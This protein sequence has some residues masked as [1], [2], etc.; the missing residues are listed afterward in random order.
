MNKYCYCWSGFETSA[1]SP[2]LLC[3]CSLAAWFPPP[4]DYAT[5]R[6]SPDG[7]PRPQNREKYISFLFK[8]S[9]LYF[10]LEAENRQD[11]F[12]NI[13]KGHYILLKFLPFHWNEILKYA[14]ERPFSPQREGSRVVSGVCFYPIVVHE[15]RWGAGG[16]SP[17]L[18]PAENTAS[19]LLNCIYRLFLL[20]AQGMALKSQW[21]KGWW[22][23]V[24]T[25]SR[26]LQSHLGMLL[27]LP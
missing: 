22:K 27:S 14:H 26:P 18:D 17:T 10:V 12:S 3:A 7:L 8:P 6:P 1:S 21:G 24:P 9:S 11:N 19:W 16:R 20:R 2:S 23:A 25:A 5:W 4:C 13:W 15:G